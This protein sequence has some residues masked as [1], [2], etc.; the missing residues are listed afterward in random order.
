MNAEGQKA[1]SLFLAAVENCAPEQ[2]GAFLED[3]CAGDQ[4]LRR[5]VEILLRAHQASNSLIDGPAPDVVATI[6]DPITERPGT[7]I[8][9]YKLMEQIGEGGMGLVFVA[10]QQH[11]VRRKVALKVIKPGMDTRHV[12]ARF[13]AERQALALM[14]HPSIAKVLDGGETAGGRPYF[15][16]ELVKGVPIT[17]YCDDNRL[18]T[19]ER[20]ELFVPVCEAVQHAHQKGIIHRDLKPSN[21]LVTSHDGK[22]VV[23][24]IDFGVAKAVGQRLTEKTVYTGFVQMIGTPLYMSPEQAGM[25]GLDVDTRSDI[26]ALGVL[27]Y[28]LLTGTTPFDQERLGAAGYDEIRRIIREEEPARPSTRLSTLAQAASTVCANRRSDPRTLSR[29]IRGEL[30]WIVMKALEKDRNRRYETASAFAADVQRYL[31]D[32]PVL[33][34]PPSA[35]YRLRKYARRHKGRLAAAAVLGVTLLTAV[36]AAAGSIGWVA[37]DRSTRQAR[38]TTQLELILDEVARLAQEQK[39][40]EAQSAAERAEAVL[41]GGEAEDA[42]RQRVA[43]ARRD[44]AFVARLDRIRQERSAVTVEGRYDHAGAARD[45]ALVFRDYGVDVEAL[46]AEEAVARLRSKGALAAPVAAALDDWVDARQS[47]GE[48]EANWQPL[49]AVARGL[50]PDPLRD[51]L[52]AA[53][54]R[55]V[56][57]VQAELRQLADSIDVK[58]QRPATIL[59]LANTLKRTQLEDSALRIVREGQ[60]AHP[61]EFWLNSELGRLLLADRKDYAG[62]LRYDT[63]AVSLRPDSAVA[64][65]NLGMALDHNKDMDG[66]I[67][68]YRKAIDLDPR[69][70]PAHNNLAITLYYKNDLEGAIAEY[71]EAIRLDKDN[72]LPHFNLGI[73][74]NAKGRLGEAIPEYRKATELDPKYTDARNNLG[75]GL[76]HKDRLDEAIAEL[77]KGTKIDPKHAVI[78]CS[79]GEVCGHLGRW[80]E[81]LAAFDKAAEL[82]PANHWY[83]FCAATVRLQTGDLAGYRAACQEMLRRFGNTADGWVAERTAKVCLSLPGAVADPDRALKLADLAATSDPDNFW[84]QFVK[85]LAEYRADRPAEAVKWLVRFAPKADGNPI[86]AQCFAVLAMARHGR[87]LAPEARA[88]LDSA[89]AILAKKTPGPARDLPYGFDWINWSHGRVLVREAEALL[90]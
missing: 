45:Y 56:T 53:W 65:N 29:L 44:L 51:R 28:E 81:A 14:D 54:G 27:L 88:A 9:P 71:H 24:V 66:A 58:S 74:L 69:Y 4:D 67:A 12:I 23:R 47:L 48:G 83:H 35:A 89:K 90:K 80:D 10:E 17:Q 43:D 21:V 1:R 52:R 20:L 49:V 8:G 61:A 15:V 31:A 39:W 78:H 84:F 76:A 70:A 33:A 3:A 40:P 30:D 13:E 46:P 60:N 19:R 18:T 62:A 77:R 26:Y 41:A 32:E 85:A 7:V 72:P 6:D 11:P 50:D 79:L 37:R 25:S 57:E 63:A 86:D 36:G 75:D 5:R 87:G 59:A 42:V 34:C 68:E 64:H 22:L 82:D 73:A 38:L 55:K 16:M 2:W